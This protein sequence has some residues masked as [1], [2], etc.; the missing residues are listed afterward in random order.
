M[1]Q[2][3]AFIKKEF[4]HI[5]RDRRTVLIVLVMPVVLIVLFGFALSTEVRNVDIAIL[6]PEPDRTIEQ[7]ADRLDASEYFTVR[8]WLRT[9][10]L[11]TCP[12]A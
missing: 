12:S 7:I 10:P 1:K 5:L 4:Y 3:G 2:F 8:Q 6:T 11:P 9:P